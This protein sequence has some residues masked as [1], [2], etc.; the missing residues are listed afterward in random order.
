MSA[1]IFICLI[2]LWRLWRYAMGHRERTMVKTA[3]PKWRQKWLYSKRRQ[4]KQHLQF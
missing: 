2:L 1:D 4:T 3:T